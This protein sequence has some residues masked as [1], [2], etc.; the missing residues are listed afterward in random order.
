MTDTKKIVSIEKEEDLEKFYLENKDVEWIGFDTEFVGEKRYYTLL[1]LIQIATENGFY[2]IDPL[3]IKDL[4][5]LLKMIE[6][7]AILKITHAGE[8]DYRLFNSYF[9]VLPKNVFDTQVAAGFIG[10][11]YPISFSQLVEKETKIHLKKGYT[12][13]DWESRP[14]NKKQMEY[15]LNDV[16]YLEQLWKSLTNK[17]EKLNR[18]EWVVE[19]FQKMELAETYYFDP[20]KEA[21]NNSIILGL[22]LKEQVFLIRLYTWRRLEAERKN[23]SKEMIL[24]AKFIAAFVRNM[25]SGKASLLNHRRVPDRIIEKNWNAFEALYHEK[26][27]EEELELLNKIP[28]SPQEN[29]SHEALMEIMYLIIKY[30]CYKKNIAPDLVV[31]RTDFKKMKAD[32]QYFDEKLAAGWRN[33]MVG[34]QMV[35]WLRNRENLE[36]SMHNGQFTM[37]VKS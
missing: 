25:K 30:K 17:L 36:I 34:E 7:P 28:P 3:K 9:G 16:I 4:T 24:P 23:Y 26:P 6:D 32:F 33:E 12:V 8:N 19:E 27:K 22:N 18:T 21:L 15:A 29:P 35:H 10:Y 2:L 13:S 20:N 1:C 31:N 5:P 11:K 37:K 14:I